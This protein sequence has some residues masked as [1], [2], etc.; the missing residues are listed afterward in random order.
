VLLAVDGH[1]NLA[2]VA[3]DLRPHAMAA[4]VHADVSLEFINPAHLA[5]P[6]RCAKS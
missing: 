4:T 1:T 6:R 5:L 2:A 3:Y